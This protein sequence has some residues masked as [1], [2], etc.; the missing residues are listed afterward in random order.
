MLDFEQR[1]NPTVAADA[2]FVKVAE[3]WHEHGFASTSSCC[4]GSGVESYYQVRFA[5]KGWK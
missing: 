2:S 1:E 5:G 4:T 3:Q